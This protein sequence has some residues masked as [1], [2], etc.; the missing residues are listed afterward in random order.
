MKMG[1]YE[2]VIASLDSFFA[3]PKGEIDWVVWGDETTIEAYKHKGVQQRSRS[4]SLS[5]NRVG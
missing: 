3:G 2:K 5:Y 1:G 4:A